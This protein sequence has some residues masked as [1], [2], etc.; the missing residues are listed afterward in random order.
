MSSKIVGWQIWC[1]VSRLKNFI[2]STWNITD[3]IK[4][5]K[6]VISRVYSIY[7]SNLDWKLILI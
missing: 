4:Y 3:G 6:N 1:K 5:D 7:M 2:S